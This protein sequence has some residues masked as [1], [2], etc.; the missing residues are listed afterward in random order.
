MT[1][2]ELLLSLL[3][4]SGVMLAAL[5]LV[6]AYGY[7]SNEIYDARPLRS[8]AVNVHAS[9]QKWLQDAQDIIAITTPLGNQL[10]I[11]DPGVKESGLTR[12]FAWMGDRAGRVSDGEVAY[13]E[14]EA[15]VWEYDWDAGKVQQMDY[16]ALNDLWDDWGSCSGCDSDYNGDDVVDSDDLSILMNNWGSSNPAFVGTL[17]H[18]YYVNEDATPILDSDLNHD[19][20][21]ANWFTA[22]AV[23]ETWSNH[24]YRFT[25]ELLT[26]GTKSS[27][28]DVRI[29]LLN[30]SDVRAD[31]DAPSGVN[32]PPDYSIHV[33]G[34]PDHYIR[35][36]GY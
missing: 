16:T 26:D 6:N 24:I 14:I 33:T 25:A 29:T 15:V 23:S 31:P 3:L 10:N 28:A 35:A 20:L 13:D 12:I 22:D 4:S 18:Y 8:E 30:F 36:E 9:V 5:A 7:A 32:V 19:Y 34:T 11:N 2:I 17:K 1:L 21:T 27:A